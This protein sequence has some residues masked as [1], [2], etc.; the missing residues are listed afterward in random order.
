MTRTARMALSASCAHHAHHASTPDQPLDTTNKHTVKQVFTDS[1]SCQQLR[2]VPLHGRY[3]THID[4]ILNTQL[5]FSSFRSQ[6]PQPETAEGFLIAC[7][8]Q[9][10]ATRKT[11]RSESGGHQVTN[12]HQKD[13]VPY[14]QRGR[15]TRTCVMYAVRWLLT[16]VRPTCGNDADCSFPRR[17]D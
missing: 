17:Q 6:N 8:D 7:R 5:L 2:Q 4:G 14:S 11:I 9:V 10:I 15:M 13:N 12:C 16:Q 1:R 3:W